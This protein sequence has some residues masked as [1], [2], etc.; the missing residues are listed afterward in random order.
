MKT[1]LMENQDSLLLSAIFYL[2]LFFSPFGIYCD[3]AD[4]KDSQNAQST[5]ENGG[6]IPLFFLSLA[7]S[8]KWYYFQAQPLLFMVMTK[9]I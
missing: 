5:L 4:H 7:R 8:M 9:V 2:L 6:E 1:F 3:Q